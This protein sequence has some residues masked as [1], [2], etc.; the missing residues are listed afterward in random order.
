MV[1]VKVKRV[2]K[3]RA[4]YKTALPTIP[5]DESNSEFL[6]VEGFQMLILKAKSSFGNSITRQSFKSGL[7]SLYTDDFSY[8]GLIK[9]SAS[10]ASYPLDPEYCDDESLFF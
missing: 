8:E 1:V 2:P 10:Y 3:N 4:V 9:R 5:E 7:S 6:Q